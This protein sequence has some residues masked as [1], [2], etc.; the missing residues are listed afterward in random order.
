[1]ARHMTPTTAVPQTKSGLDPEI[2][3]T[4]DA[5]IIRTDPTAIRVV[6]S[7]GFNR[8]AY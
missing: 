6:G 7:F 3:P 1:M 5:T 4:T 2:T 8:M